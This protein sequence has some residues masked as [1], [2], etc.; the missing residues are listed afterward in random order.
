MCVCVGG[1]GGGGGGGSSW[2]LGTHLPQNVTNRAYFPTAGI[3]LLGTSS[4]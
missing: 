2:R 3:A 4:L 1:G